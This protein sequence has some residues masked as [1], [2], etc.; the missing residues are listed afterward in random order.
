[1]ADTTLHHTVSGIHGPIIEHRQAVDAAMLDLA[2]SPD[3]V[4]GDVVRMSRSKVEAHYA[5][6]G[7]GYEPDG[8]PLIQ[9]TVIQRLK[10]SHGST[11]A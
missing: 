3:A 6:Y 9:V 4:L 5:D 11:D 8:P 2:L 7:R 10:P 1:M